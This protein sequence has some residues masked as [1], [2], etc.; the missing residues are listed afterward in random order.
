MDGYIA[1]KTGKN[2]WAK[3][4]ELFKKTLKEY[5]TVVIGNRTFEQNIGMI[6]PFKGV[7]NLVL[8]HDNKKSNKGE[9]QYVSSVDEAL[10]TAKILGSRRLLVA[11]GS[12]TNE[13][14]SE[15]GVLNRL[16]LDIH[17]TKIGG[18]LPLFGNFTGQLPIKLT[19]YSVLPEG[20]TRMKYNVGKIKMTA[21]KNK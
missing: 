6:Y 13:A 18:G 3:D 21:S 7:H 4:A 8:S 19:G 1:D 17:P 5:D 10:K 12:R 20:F 9:V 11:G 14:F 2:D 16:I 15:A